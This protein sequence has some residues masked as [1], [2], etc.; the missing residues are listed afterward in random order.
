MLK[1]GKP[2]IKGVVYMLK[3][4]TLRIVLLALLSSGLCT[5]SAFAVQAKQASNQQ[6][7]SSSKSKASPAS[8]PSDSDMDVSK[9][10]D[11]KSVD[12]QAK[13]SNPVP[14]I[15]VNWDIY[16]GYAFA[17]WS[18]FTSGGHGA[19]ALIGGI[20]P[21]NHDEGGFS[22]GADLGY[23][24]IRYFGI[25]FGYSYFRRV[26]GNNLSIQ[27]PYYYFAGKVSYPFLENDNLSIFANF[28]AALRELEYSGS[29]AQGVYNNKRYNIR[30]V[31]GLGIQ[32]YFSHRWK[33][34]MQWLEVPKY[35]S[36]DVNSKDSS[37]QIPRTDQLLIGLGYLFTI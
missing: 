17:N 30:P 31:Y 32:Y 23:Q 24:I 34:T 1:F 2:A 4:K 20:Q 10:T 9:I 16:L 33:A 11:G 25:E 28:G 6:V 22:F 37:K 18:E 12:L 21:R 19:W 13:I 5:V 27:T 3:G 36:G 29:S 7:D 26:S 8:K 15:G 14:H 35:T